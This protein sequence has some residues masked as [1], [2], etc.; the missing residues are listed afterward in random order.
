[1]P[2]EKMSANRLTQLMPLTRSS[3]VRRVERH[4]H[5]LRARRLWQIALIGENQSGQRMIGGNPPVHHDRLIDR[6]HCLEQMLLDGG[7]PTELCLG[8]RRAQMR[9]SQFAMY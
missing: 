2:I 9:E 7:N 4:R 1:M 8:P 6:A 3:S 5:G